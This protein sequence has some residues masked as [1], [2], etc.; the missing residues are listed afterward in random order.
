MEL[1]DV[2]KAITDIDD[3]DDVFEKMSEAGIICPH[4]ITGAAVE[5]PLCAGKAAAEVKANGN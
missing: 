3:M 5:C 1:D 4:C 2:L